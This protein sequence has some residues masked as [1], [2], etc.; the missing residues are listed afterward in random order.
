MDFTAVT[1]LFGTTHTGQFSEHTYAQLHDIYVDNPTD[2]IKNAILSELWFRDKPLYITT[3]SLHAKDLLPQYEDEITSKLV[4]AFHGTLT[5]WNEDKHMKYTTFIVNSLKQDIYDIRT[6]SQAQKRVALTSAIPLEPWNDTTEYDDMGEAVANLEVL[7]RK[8]FTKEQY[9]AIMLMVAGF[10]IG[11][12][13]KHTGMDSKT[14]RQLQETL[15]Q[16][17]YNA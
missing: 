11:E 3:I 12:T 4:W 5:A 8:L 6:S 1:E 10:G 16:E 7:C 17:V 2:S 15:R 9:R 14:L 13:T